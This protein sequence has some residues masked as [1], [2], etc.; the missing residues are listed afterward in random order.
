MGRLLGDEPR[1]PGGPLI[2][3]QPQPPRKIPRLPRLYC[4]RIRG[5]RGYLVQVGSV[6]DHKALY[7]CQACGWQGVLPVRPG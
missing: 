5:H 4:G 3:S 7:R 2:V 1:A 6:R